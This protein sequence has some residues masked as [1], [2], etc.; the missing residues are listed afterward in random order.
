MTPHFLLVECPSIHCPQLFSPICGSYPTA[1]GQTFETFANDCELKVATCNRGQ[2]ISV[3]FQGPC[4]LDENLPVLEAVEAEADE[5]AEE[6]NACG[7]RVC[8]QVFAP[9][10]GTNGKKLSCHICLNFLAF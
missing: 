7:H 10:C 4:P 6:E 2:N 5:N 1:N 8:A 3:A 9:V